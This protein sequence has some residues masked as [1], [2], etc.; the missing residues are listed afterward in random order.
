MNDFAP[1]SMEEASGGLAVPSSPK[2]LGILS[3][4]FASLMLL[5]NLPASCMGFFG[6][7]VTEMGSAFSTEVQDGEAFQG[8]M[9]V[10]GTIYRVAGIQGLI[11]LAMSG[12][13]LGIGVGQLKYRRW[14]AKWSVIWGG[15]GLGVLAIIA[16]LMIFVLGPAYERMFEAV[17]L[18]DPEAEKAAE[19]LAGFGSMMGGWASAIQVIILAPYPILMIVFFRKPNIVQAMSR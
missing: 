18:A 3:I 15:M 1:H 8:M 9:E 17:A 16:G 7:A 13:L 12:L 11:M 19:M 10:V 5:V 14:A 4:I 6:S 2:V